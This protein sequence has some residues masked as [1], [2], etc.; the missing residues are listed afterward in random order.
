MELL[1][2]LAVDYGVTLVSGILAAWLISLIKNNNFKNWGITVGKLLSK[3][4]SKAG[5]KSWEKLEDSIIIAFISFA[6]GLKEGADWDDNDVIEVKE[7]MGHIKQDIKA[8]EI[9]K[10]NDEIDEIKKE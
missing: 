7:D 5:K 1:K 6:T 3:F 4:G 10:K 8:D 2:D 9:E